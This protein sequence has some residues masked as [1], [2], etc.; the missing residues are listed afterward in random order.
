MPLPCSAWPDGAD[1]H[2]L[3][4]GTVFIWKK[5]DFARGTELAC[6]RLVYSNVGL[7]LSE[8]TSHI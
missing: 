3:C 8:F 5:R 1:G 4:S 2:W 6:S 7:E